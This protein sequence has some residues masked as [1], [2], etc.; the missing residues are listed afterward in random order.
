MSND[1][2]PS[3]SAT[4]PTELALDGHAGR[5]VGCCWPAPSPRAVVLIAHGYGEH[6]RRYDHVAARLNA[7]GL[8]LYAADHAGHGRSDG[9][10]VLIPD[11]E[12]VVADL[13]LV[14]EHAVNENPGLPIVLI[15]HSMG[16][17]IA[18]RFT[19]L[20]GE[21]LT[22]LV[23]SGPVLGRWETVEQ[24]LAAE[25]IPDDP[26]DTSTLSR[27]PE[28]GRRYEADPLIWHGPFQRPTLQGLHEAMD[29]INA[30]GSI[31]DLPLLYLH[32][33]ADQL[34]PIE[35]SLGGLEKIRGPRTQKKTYPGARHEIFNETNSAEVLDDVVAFVDR[36]LAG[37]V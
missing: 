30:A 12:P 3:G 8:S 36:V 9:E 18:A 23:L 21:E 35:D 17:M 16:G 26:I 10:R 11:F 29:R 24:L 32:G 7:A 13:Q 28:V 5:L 4:V 6:V 22:A 20:H 33:E 25:E 19:Q 27:D 1:T 2:A 14:L 34:V 15:G 31:G 37:E